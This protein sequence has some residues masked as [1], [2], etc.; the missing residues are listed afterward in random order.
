MKQEF[1]TLSAS[2]WDKENVKYTSKITDNTITNDFLLPIVDVLI[3]LNNTK[4]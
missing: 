4:N 2:I 3:D 1:L